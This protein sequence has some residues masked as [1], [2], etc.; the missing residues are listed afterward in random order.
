MNYV[1]ILE[2][3]DNTLYTGWIWRKGS[4]F[5]PVERE[6]NIQGEGFQ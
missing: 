6:Q 5:I 1:Y 4:R 3:C 2:C